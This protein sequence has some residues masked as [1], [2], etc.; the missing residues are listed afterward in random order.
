[1]FVVQKLLD[2]K[3][4]KPSARKLACPQVSQVVDLLSIR[5]QLPPLLL[6]HSRQTTERHLLRIPQHEQEGSGLP[7][8]RV[9]HILLAVPENG[10]EESRRGGGEL[11][12]GED[13]N[14]EAEQDHVSRFNR[15]RGGSGRD[16]SISAA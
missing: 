10:A 2:L 5:P 15:L 3:R 8:R 12:P 14:G 16:R 6:D 11:L 13:F 9:V 4:S 7:R 1:M